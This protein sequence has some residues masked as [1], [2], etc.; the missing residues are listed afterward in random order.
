MTITWTSHEHLE[1]MLK[2]EVGIYTTS[3]SRAPIQVV[4]LKSPF[5]VH[6][7]ANMNLR[8]AVESHN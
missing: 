7:N 6:T 2:G 8:P 3:C 4:M 1:C 5:L